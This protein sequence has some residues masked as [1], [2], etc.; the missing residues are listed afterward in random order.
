MAAGSSIEILTGLSSA[1]A[2]S[3]SFATSASVGFEYEVAS[4]DHPHGEARADGERRL[5]RELTAHDLLT[6]VVDSVLGAALDG[7]DEFVLIVGREFG[8]NAE[9]RR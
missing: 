9:K 1:M 5:D 3:F 7:L 4:Y 2:P 6:G 8:S